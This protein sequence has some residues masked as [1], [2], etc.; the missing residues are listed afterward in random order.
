MCPACISVATIVAL[1]ATGTGALTAFVATTLF[2]RK[3]QIVP[4]SNHS[5]GV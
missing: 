5:E 4:Q 2:K 3:K 1:S